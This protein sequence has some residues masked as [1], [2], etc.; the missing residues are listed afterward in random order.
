MVDS[1]EHRYDVF[2]SYARA[3]DPNFRQAL[4][5]GLARA[6]C[7]VWLDREVMP[8]R[9]TT[10][11]QEIRRAIEACDRLVLLAGPGALSSEY[12]TQEWRYADDIGKP[13]V[14]VVRSTAFHDLPERLRHYHG[15][16][17]RQQTVDTVVADLAR[18]LGEPVR[19]LGPITTRTGDHGIRRTPACGRVDRVLSVLP[20]PVTAPARPRPRRA[21]R[22]PVA[23][24]PAGPDA[25]T[26]RR[27]GATRGGALR[28][29][30]IREEHGC[31]RLRRGHPH[32]SGVL[33]RHRLA[34]R[35]NRVRRCALRHRTRGCRYPPMP[36]PPDPPSR[37]TVHEDSR[38]FRAVASVADRPTAPRS[39]AAFAGTRSTAHGARRPP[40]GLP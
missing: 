28:R 3:D 33:R 35:R 31:R 19:P 14:P 16:E 11:G 34:H 17:A 8:N 18:L 37:K 13:V 5:D 39:P 21:D 2:L 20:P 30:R 23:H 7:R 29:P 1:G 12:V 38:G 6:G 10:F 27:P 24:T 40:P 4:S 22:T 25:P 9:G 26:G 15:V 32:P 36:L